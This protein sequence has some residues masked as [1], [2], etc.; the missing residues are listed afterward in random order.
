TRQQYK[1]NDSCRIVVVVLML[2]V[3]RYATPLYP[4]PFPFFSSPLNS[5][6]S[7]RKR[8]QPPIVPRNSSSRISTTADSFRRK[9]TYFRGE[10]TV[11]KENQPRSHQP[12]AT[13][14]HASRLEHLRRYDQ[15]PPRS[16]ITA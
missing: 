11:L 5:A 16:V 2:R 15:P 1:K 14:P 3:S 12:P 9:G 8:P 6:Y 10:P 13:P 7:A 4:L